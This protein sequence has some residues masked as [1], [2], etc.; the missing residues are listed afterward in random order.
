MHELYATQAILEK[1]VQKANEANAKRVTHLY[2]VVG[3][4]STYSEESVRFYWNEICKGTP[5][6]GAEL[7]FRQVPAEAQCMACFTKYHPRE[8]EIVCPQCGS[9]GAKVIAGEEFFMEALDV[10]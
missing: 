8:G 6:E 4:I 5:A 9:V 10:E 1:A 7:H 3:E 2:L